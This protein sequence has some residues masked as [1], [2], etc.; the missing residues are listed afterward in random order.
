MTSP[1]GP[2]TKAIRT[3]AGGSPP[4]NSWRTEQPRPEFPSSRWLCGNH[5]QVVQRDFNAAATGR[6]VSVFNQ[7]CETRKSDAKLQRHGN[8]SV[9]ARSYDSVSADCI[10]S[11]VLT[12]RARA[13]LRKTLGRP[14]LLPV[15]MSLKTEGLIPT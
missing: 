15:S 6:A 1:S 12:S 7:P 13:I 2:V 10:N 14:S 3:S 5:L 9:S 11:S 4:K 8:F